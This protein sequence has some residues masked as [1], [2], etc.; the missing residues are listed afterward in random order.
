MAFAA[1]TTGS[2]VAHSATHS[3]LSARAAQPSPPVFQG[4]GSRVLTTTLRA[5]GPLIVAAAHN[6]SQ[7]FVIKIVGGGSS[8]LLVNEI[9]NYSGRVVW[10]DARKGT[11]RI[12]VEADGAWKLV[13]YQPVPADARRNI[14][15]SFSG[16]GS[17][18]IV[19]R[20][21]RSIQ[22]IL[23]ATHRGT[24]NF[25]VRL[26]GF[27][28]ISGTNLLVNEIGNYKGQTLLDAEL[29]P[30]TYVIAVEADGLWTLKFS[31]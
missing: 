5:T 6:G 14:T 10:D 27:G 20:T 13:L 8:E 21:T 24:S 16:K 25:V 26:I 11:Y 29:P 31:P 30:G 9:G 12:A 1:A 17:Q 18:A 3:R 23:T 19:V 4:Q 15:G 22:P 2:A 28:S 7:N